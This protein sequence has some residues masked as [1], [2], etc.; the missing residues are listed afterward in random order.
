MFNHN[1]G[2]PLLV[3]IRVLFTSGVDGYYVGYRR[4]VPKVL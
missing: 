1:K 4:D 2:I 3:N